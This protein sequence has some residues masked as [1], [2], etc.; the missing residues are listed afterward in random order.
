MGADDEPKGPFA[1]AGPQ[2]AKLGIAV[3]PCGGD[4]GKKPLIKQPQR[5]GCGAVAELAARF[6][7]ANVGIWCGASNKIT[8]VDIDEADPGLEALAVER[9]GKTPV[10]VRTGS[11]KLHLYYRHAGERRAIRPFDDLEID[12]LG[13]GGL[14]IAPPSKRPGGGLYSFELGWLDAFAD[15][16]TIKA[17]SLPTHIYDKKSTAVPDRDSAA[18]RGNDIGHRNRELFAYGLRA[19]KKT[20]NIND[21]LEQL[22]Q[23]NHAFN[24]P[25][26]ANEV[27][28]I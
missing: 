2:Y 27:L 12:I 4:S 5:V 18:V 16:P 7:T 28:S 6:P 15:L 20:D 17:G 22:L 21:L 1:L 14:A 11:R 26:E 13:E 19:V 10:R 3:F 8:I 24:P 23:R 25:L 9:F